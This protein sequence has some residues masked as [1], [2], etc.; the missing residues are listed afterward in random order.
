MRGRWKTLVSTDSWAYV[1]CP[2][3]VYLNVIFVINL[4]YNAGRESG[5]LTDWSEYPWSESQL[6]STLWCALISHKVYRLSQEVLFQKTCEHTYSPDPIT[7][8]M[9]MDGLAFTVSFLPS[10]V[11]PWGNHVSTKP[12][13]WRTVS[14]G[15]HTELLKG[16]HYLRPLDT[17]RKT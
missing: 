3:L 6:H 4:F 13:P 16:P 8:G 1:S 15:P 11:S 2:L 10:W 17:L 12:C 5:C 9:D 14:V 7:P